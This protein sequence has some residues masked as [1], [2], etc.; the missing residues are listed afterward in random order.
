MNYQYK[1]LVIDDTPE[2]I[3]T[4][5]RLLSESEEVN[6]LVYGAVNGK[7][8]LNA[9]TKEKF[10]CVFVDY[11]LPEYD[12]TELIKIIRKN[13]DSQDIPIILF[14]AYGT[15]PRAAA[16][17]KLGAQDYVSKDNFDTEI[18]VRAVHYAIESKRADVAQ[19]KLIV[20]LQKALDEV[21]ILR[22]LLP[23]CSSCKKVRDDN[24]NWHEIERYIKDNSEA[25]FTHGICPE[26][27]KTWYPDEDT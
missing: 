22:G 19:D 12:G 11:M 27:S 18:L 24:D 5:K 6:Y 16:A 17:L 1:I 8:G 13:P 9:L 10:D 15:G 14:T 23:I 26:C 7:K 20:D 4:V 2:D 3:E 25:D 21:K